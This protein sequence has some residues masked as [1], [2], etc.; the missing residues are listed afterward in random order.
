MNHKIGDRVKIRSWNSMLNEYGMY[1][2]KA[3]NTTP[4]VFNDIMLNYCN[5]FVTISKI[6]EDGSFGIEEDN[7]MWMWCDSML[8]NR[9]SIKLI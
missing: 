5:K 9:H 6:Y 4:Y 1:S 3:I 8:V 2:K 7:G